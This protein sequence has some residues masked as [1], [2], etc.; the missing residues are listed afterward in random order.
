[1]SDTDTDTKTPRATIAV[2]EWIDVDG[3]PIESGEEANATGFRYIHLPTA[4]RLDPKWDKE[5]SDPAPAGSA[6]E[7]QIPDGPVK[8]MLAV[9][10]GLTLTGNEVN[11]ATKGA[12]GDPNANP[13]PDVTEMYK[14]MIEGNLW[15]G[16]GG[17]GGGG[18]RYDKEK[19]A[20]A[21]ANAKGETDPAP[22]LAKIPLKV[23]TK[24]GAIVANDT[25]GAI[26]WG[27]YAMRVPQV[28]TEYNKLTG[29]G[30]SLANL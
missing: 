9:F 15:R 1:M 22:Y 19:L 28:Q 20:Q 3:N 29:S 2:R 30:V 21:I 26:S 8:T 7:L 25:K 18:V 10:G 12:K 5:S 27:A 13:I 16:G 6:F 11:T 17:A 23:D 14:A 4:L 24:T